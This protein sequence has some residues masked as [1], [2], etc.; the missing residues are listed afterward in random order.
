METKKRMLQ[1]EISNLMEMKFDYEFEADQKDDFRDKA[2]L[3][4]LSNELN[5]EIEKLC[6]KLDKG[7]DKNTCPA[8]FQ[9]DL[10]CSMCMYNDDLSTFRGCNCQMCSGEIESCDDCE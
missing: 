2:V 10:I 3:L 8:K 4:N 6:S 9:T 5:G 1:D 7:Y